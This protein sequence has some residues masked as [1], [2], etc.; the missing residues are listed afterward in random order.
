M[1]AVDGRVSAVL[2]LCVLFLGGGEFVSEGDDGNHGL[3]VEGG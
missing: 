1:T 2:L 3:G